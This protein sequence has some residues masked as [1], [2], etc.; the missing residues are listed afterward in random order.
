MKAP[1]EIWLQIDDS[2]GEK[3][4]DELD[5]THTC[6]ERVFDTDIRYIRADADISISETTEIIAR[7]TKQLGIQRTGE[8]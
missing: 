5:Y 3:F 8:L 4:E 1:N 6:H 7:L 2:H